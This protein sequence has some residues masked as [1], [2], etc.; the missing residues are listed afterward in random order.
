[1]TFYLSCQ[2]YFWNEY[3]NTYFYNTE[4]LWQQVFT[5]LVKVLQFKTIHSSPIREH[6]PWVQATSEFWTRDPSPYFIFLSPFH[7]LLA[8]LPKVLTE[9]KSYI[10]PMWSV[11][12]QITH[13][14][15]ALPWKGTSTQACERPYAYLFISVQYYFGVTPMFMIFIAFKVIFPSKFLSSVFIILMHL[16]KPATSWYSEITS[17]FEDSDVERYL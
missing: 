11:H 14:I 16:G 3:V 13:Y 17:E 12:L 8:C 4:T 5:F 6:S 10:A 15:R 7:F 1:M 9:S 2:E